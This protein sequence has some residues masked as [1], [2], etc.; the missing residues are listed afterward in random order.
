MEQPSSQ[1]HSAYQHHHHHHQ[2]CH[3]HNHHH[4]LCTL[5]PQYHPHLHT[6]LCPLRYVLPP[7]IPSQTQFRNPVSAPE[8]S[9]LEVLEEPQ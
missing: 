3:N 1:S 2:H 9:N 7:P 8:I 5:K 4:P 6:N